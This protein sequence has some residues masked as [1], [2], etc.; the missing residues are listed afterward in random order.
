MSAAAVVLCGVTGQPVR[1]T[2]RLLAAAALL[3]GLDAAL[4]EAPGGCG[5]RG[6]LVHVRMG[7]EVR[8]AVA[9]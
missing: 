3:A 9:P 1:E 8:A 6:L 2:A 7:Q 5:R 4:S